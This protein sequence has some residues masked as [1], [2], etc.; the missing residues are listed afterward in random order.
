[1]PEHLRPPE[2]LDVREVE[3]AVLT[4]YAGLFLRHLLDW[5]DGD[6]T[7]AVAAYNGGPGNPNLVYGEGV[8]NAAGHAR[9]IL[10][11]VAALNGESAIHTQWLR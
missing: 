6:A 7:L 3:P 1:L 10:E 2:K 4:T 5:F 9:R 8:Q 11:Q